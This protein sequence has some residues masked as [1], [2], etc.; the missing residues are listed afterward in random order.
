[1]PGYKIGRCQSRG[2]YI[3]STKSGPAA[4]QGPIDTI[5]LNAF[6]YITHLPGKA[7]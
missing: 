6:H 1:M 7:Q 5:R 2:P 3:A 4:W